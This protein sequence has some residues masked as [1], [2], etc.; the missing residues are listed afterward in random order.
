M[1]PEKQTT[2]RFNLMIP[3]G[4]Q[5]VTEE[6]INEV[7]SVLKSDY[8]TQGPKLPEF[9]A[10][11]AQTVG[12][13]Y[14]IAVNSATSALHL[15]CLAL[16]LGAGD[17]LWTS[18]ISFVASSNCAIYCGAEVDFVDIDVN[19]INICVNSLKL[20]LEI[21]NKSGRLPKILV[22]VH[23]CGTPANMEAIHQLSLTYGFKIIEDAS[24][25]V[26]ARYNGTQIGDCKYS[27]IA[28]FSLHPVKIITTGEGGIL[29]T[30]S[31]KIVKDVALC[32]SHGITRDPDLFENVAH[33]PWYYEQITLGYNYRLTEIQAAL[34]ISQLNRLKD[35]VSK[36][37]TIHQHYK[38]LLKGLPLFHQEISQGTTS[39]MHLHILQVDL[40]KV[41]ISRKTIFSKLQSF[42]VGANVH[43]MPIVMQPYYRKLGFNLSNYPNAELYYSRCF[44]IP[45]FPELTEDQQR[46]VANSVKL[47]L[48]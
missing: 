5:N 7:L 41:N 44:T 12:A 27:D 4:K 10:Q 42:G 3:Y 28:V 47:A 29:T 43:Y 40:N 33:G 36:R 37:N 23:M 11:F 20:K 45:L 34:G 18:P 38:D 13:E 48:E 26:G 15:S 21:A 16:G 39:S 46:Y 17:I 19:T 24:H 30:N 6:D 22:V 14:A 1:D 35:I 25:A 9:E 32:R 8:L 2:N 31:K